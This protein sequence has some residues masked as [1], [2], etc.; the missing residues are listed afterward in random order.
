VSLTMIVRDE[1]KDLPRSL[2]SVRGVFDEIVVVDT[3]SKDRTIEI[4]RS[5]GARVFDFVWVDDFGAARNAALALA[6]GDYA[7]WL[8]ADDLI[9]PAEREKLV[10][11]L[12][13]LRGEPREALVWRLRGSPQRGRGTG[14]HCRS[15]SPF[16][17]AGARDIGSDVLGRSQSLVRFA[18][19]VRC[20]CVPGA[21]GSGGET[22]VDHVRLFPLLE[23]VRWTYRVHEQILPALKRA[24]VP[25]QW[26]DITVRHTGYSDRTLRSRKLDRDGRILR[27]ELA[28]RPDDPFA[29]FNL[30]ALAIKRAEW[31]EALRFLRRSLAGS[32][33]TDSI[34]RKLFA[35]IARAHQMRGDSQSGLDCCAEGLSLDSEDAELWFRKAVVHRQRGE[36][37]EAE[38][39]WCMI[40]TLSRPQKFASVRIA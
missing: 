29:L 19:V 26:T 14:I 34:T 31:D 23:G 20:A 25:V 4:A 6:T 8:D 27:E 38:E 5:F 37:R 9:E 7:F 13:E 3:G 24:G 10:G 33:P 22:V 15:Q 1:E 32:A 35:L 21:E 28:E 17:S 12:D 11:L 16:A 30:G 18:F 40:L 39:C 36:S 2:E